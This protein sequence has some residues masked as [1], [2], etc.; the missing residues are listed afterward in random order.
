[1]NYVYFHFWTIDSLKFWNV[2]IIFIG[3]LRELRRALEQKEGMHA[4]VGPAA[5]V[6]LANVDELNTGLG[7]P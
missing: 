3:M 6:I 1:M 4:S 7:P 5:A 2:L